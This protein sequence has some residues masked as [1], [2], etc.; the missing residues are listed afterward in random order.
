MLNNDALKFNLKFSSSSSESDSNSSE[1]SEDEGAQKKVE[2]SKNDFEELVSVEPK[3]LA[4]KVEPE[5][6]PKP[7]KRKTEKSDSDES[8]D[9]SSSDSSE[10]SSDSDQD[11]KPK[12]KTVSGAV[13]KRSEPTNLDLLLSLED[14]MPTSMTSPNNVLTPTMGGLLT[15]MASQLPPGTESSP[16]SE[17]ASMF[18]PTKSIELLNKMT[19]GGLQVLQRFTRS[20]YLYSGAMC[21]IQVFKTTTI[22]RM[23]FLWS[24]SF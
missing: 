6:K 7:E 18:V 2:P 5:V 19:S 15:P 13:P 8:S 14:S 3:K 4:V 16:I 22:L 20:P 10:S 11:V 1:G 23:T 12:H 21:N 24:V 17:A 9:D